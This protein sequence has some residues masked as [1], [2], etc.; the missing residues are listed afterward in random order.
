VE[1]EVAGD[2]GSESKKKVEIGLIGRKM[3]PLSIFEKQIGAP[4]RVRP[5]LGR[6]NQ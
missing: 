5:F 3:E 1:D 2:G 6:N 4:T